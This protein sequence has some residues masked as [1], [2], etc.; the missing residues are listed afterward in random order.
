MD[1]LG[2]ESI[3]VKGTNLS[4]GKIKMTNELKFKIDETIQL[5][6]DILMK[7][8]IDATELS[9]IINI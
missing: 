8:Q 4:S 5:Q 2:I 3:F 6:N 7:N 9:L 1:N